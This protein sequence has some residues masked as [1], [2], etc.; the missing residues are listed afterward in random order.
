MLR[1]GSRL[2]AAQ[3]TVLC[4]AGCAT[5]AWAQQPRMRTVNKSPGVSI[6]F[7]LTGRPWYVIRCATLSFVRLLVPVPLAACCSRRLLM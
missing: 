4:R 6:H 7:H 5:K 1:R 2:R 3:A